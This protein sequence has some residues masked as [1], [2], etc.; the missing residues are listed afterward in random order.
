M[1][2]REGEHLA[3]GL[4]TAHEMPIP[5]HPRPPAER[6][7]ERQSERGAERDKERQSERGAERDRV[8]EERQ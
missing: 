7:K 2:E 8:R 1:R 4:A 6:D 3:P 5:I